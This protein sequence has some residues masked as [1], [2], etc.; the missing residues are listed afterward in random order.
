MIGRREPPP[1]SDGSK[2]KGFDDFD[3]RLGDVMRGE[4]ATLGKSLLDVQR[5]LKIKATYIAAIENA[6]PSAFETQGFIAGYVRSYARYLGLDPEWAYE[7]FCAEANFETAH[8]MSPAASTSRTVSA[9]QASSRGAVDPFA[10]PDALFVPRGEA[11][12]SRVEPGAIGSLLVLVMLISAIGY[13]AFSVFR[14]VQRVDLAPVDAAAGV[15][16]DLSGLAGA[17]RPGAGGGAADG[18]R[19]TAL[20]RPS[21]DALDRLY[22]PQA[23]DV[24]VLTARDAPI[25]TLDPADIGT[26]AAPLDDAELAYEPELDQPL[27]DAAPGGL[28]AGPSGDT[29]VQVV[30]AEAPEVVLFAVRPSWVRVQAADGSVIFEKILDVGEKFTLPKTEEPPLLRAGNS[31]SVYF[32]VNGR[33]Y[34]PA[35]TGPSVV[36]NIPLSPDALTAKYAEADVSKDSDLARFL[37]VAQAEGGN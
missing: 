20:V 27:N 7:R 15:T 2:L 4:R 29:A 28:E 3:L 23:L 6:D 12:L 9:V 24:P 11:L 34:G 14:A 36:K 21:V 37:A 8:G 10:D 13:G 32:T 35:G 18:A 19:E 30:G 5:D 26:L 1:A 17:V 25:A 22:R 16:G 33:N 31:G